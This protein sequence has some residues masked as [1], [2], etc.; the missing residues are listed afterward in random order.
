MNELTM[1]EGVADND[2]RE[3]SLDEIEMIGGGNN[4]RGAPR[5]RIPGGGSG[6]FGPA[7]YAI[8]LAAHYIRDTWGDQIHRAFFG[9]GESTVRTYGQMSRHKGRGSR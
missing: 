3:L 1:L 4:S 2:I 5:P 8:D 9:D 7:M 6:W